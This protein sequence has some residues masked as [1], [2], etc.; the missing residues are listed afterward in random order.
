MRTIALY[1]DEIK[2]AH[3]MYDNLTIKIRYKPKPIL[4]K[5]LYSWDAVLDN[6]TVYIP[7]SDILGINKHQLSNMI[8]KRIAKR[9][10]DMIVYNPSDVRFNVDRG[11]LSD[12]VLMIVEKLL[13]TVE[14]LPEDKYVTIGVR[15]HMVLYDIT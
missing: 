6:I 1:H 5:D 12:I 4:L 7:A 9:I 2:Y 14:L 8:L 13:L 10:E 15:D 3:Q 11:S